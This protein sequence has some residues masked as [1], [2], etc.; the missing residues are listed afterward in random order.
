MAKSI[1]DPI[2]FDRPLFLLPGEV[3]APPARG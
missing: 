1:E 2:A 3:F